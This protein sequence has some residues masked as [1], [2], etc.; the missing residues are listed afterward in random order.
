MLYYTT[1]Y[2]KIQAATE[3][4]RIL[5]K[6][7]AGSPGQRPAGNTSAAKTAQ[8]ARRG[9]FRGL[10][11]PSPV[12]AR[13]R[14]SRALLCRLGAMPGLGPASSFLAM[15]D[16][17]LAAVIVGGGEAGQLAV[18][19]V[20][21][22]FPLGVQPAAVPSALAFEVG[23]GLGKPLF[24]LNLL[25]LGLRAAGVFGEGTGGGAG[26]GAAV[27]APL[28]SSLAVGQHDCRRGGREAGEPRRGAPAVRP[29]R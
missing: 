1:T 8:E 4:L 19:S 16:P 25:F 2:Y 20:L 29:L 24:L 3:I 27:A 6:R 14:A 9:V 21:S 12:R 11:A 10:S 23:H 15:G 28:V 17:R 26:I 13:L 5:Q 18:W 22:P 7:Y